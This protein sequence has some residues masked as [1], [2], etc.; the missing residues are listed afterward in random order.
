MGLRANLGRCLAEGWTI[1]YDEDGSYFLNAD[2]S[3]DLILICRQA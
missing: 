2:R 1:F 3:G